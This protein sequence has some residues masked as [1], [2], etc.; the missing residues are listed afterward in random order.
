[1]QI[2]EYK[3]T[4]AADD[5]DLIVGKVYANGRAVADNVA[6]VFDVTKLEEF[7]PEFKAI[8]TV[9]I[10]TSKSNS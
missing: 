2:T 10:I 6:Y 5:A 9:R 4:L 7:V 8:T 1:M 3:E